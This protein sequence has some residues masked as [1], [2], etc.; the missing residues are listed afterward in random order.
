M[1]TGRLTKNK[2]EIN[3]ELQADLNEKLKIIQNK[4]LKE[5]VEINVEFTYFVKD[6]KKDGGK[7]IT[8][9]GSV[10]KI[11]EYKHSIFLKCEEKILK[12]RSNKEIKSIEK[13]LN[14]IQNYNELRKIIEIPIIDILDI[15]LK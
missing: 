7:Y 8:V 9:F 4:I 2:I 11:D 13:N 5:N 12:M 14:V 10:E 15:K 3:E 6:L 1:E